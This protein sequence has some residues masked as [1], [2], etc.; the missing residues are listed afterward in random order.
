MPDQADADAVVQAHPYHRRMS[1]VLRALTAPAAEQIRRW[2]LGAFPHGQSTIE[3][4]QPLGDPGIFGPDSVTW[5]IHSEFPG[6][7]SGGL[8]ALML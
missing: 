2:V 1:A 3:Y 7:L 5:R 8:C 4:D 6:M